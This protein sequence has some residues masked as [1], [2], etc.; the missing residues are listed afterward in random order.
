MLFLFTRVI[1]FF[2]HPRMRTSHPA[3]AYVIPPPSANCYNSAPTK[4]KKGLYCSPYKDP[5]RKHLEHNG[6]RNCVLFSKTNYPKYPY[7]SQCFFHRRERSI[8]MY[9]EYNLP[10]QNKKSRSVIVR[11]ELAGTGSPGTSYQLSEIQLGSKIR[12]ICFYTVTSFIAVFLFVVM[13]VGH[14]FV[15]L[16]DRCQRNFHNFI[17]KIWASMTIGPFFSVKIQGY[18]NL[19]P[20]DSPAVYVSN[21]QSFLDIYTLLTLGRNFKFVSKTAIFLYPVVG[22]AMYLLGTI[23]LKRMD[24][25]SQLQT[26]K[27]CMELVKNGGSVFFFPEGTRSKDGSLGA[28]KKGA[29]SIAA[30]TGAPVIPITL[31]GTGK[32]MPAGMEGTVNAGSV[33]I[34]IHPPVIGDNPDILCNEVRN[35][36]AD[37]LV[38]KD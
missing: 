37:E 31:V 13:V 23:P 6:I 20:K 11:S 38:R 9:A 35:V 22:W 19:P 16:K 10:N 14:P 26:L 8:S 1:P 30:K 32:I 24:R 5:I 34:V 4:I 18:E 29:F 17:A 27:R 3:K 25:K 28:F 36:I 2:L 12:G 15:L 7:K 21:H 33:K